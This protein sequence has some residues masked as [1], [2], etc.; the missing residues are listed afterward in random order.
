MSLHATECGPVINKQSA[1][2]QEHIAAS[3]EA[4]LVAVLESA[5]VVG[6]EEL[7]VVEPEKR[8]LY[9][10]VV[11]ASALETAVVAAQ[12]F[13]IMWTDDGVAASLFSRESFAGVHVWTQAILRWLNDE[14]VLD[15]DAYTQA[16]ARLVGWRYEFTS[17]NP[18]I[19]QACGNLAEWNV[20]RWPLQQA[21]QYLALGTVNRSDAAFLG[22]KLLADGYL[23][24]VLSET[25]TQLVASVAEAIARR[26]D[27]EE[28]LRRF[29][30]AL[31][32]T[33][34]L[35]AVGLDDCLRTIS[36]WQREY[37]RRP[38]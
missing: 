23:D 9:E 4:F 35:N 20:R 12:P 3:A 32:R 8:K 2:E 5:T 36:A 24:T 31:R 26:D 30:G 16:S 15:A 29:A 10:D 19:L 7:A 37:A 18:K 28:A 25:R 38:R 27:H 13:R 6:C 34:G 14:G 17:V 1:D 22:A 33:F 11:G 21:V